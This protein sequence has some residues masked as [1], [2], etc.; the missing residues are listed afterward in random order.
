[1]AL[2]S[3]TKIRNIIYENLSVATS[4]GSLAANARFKTEH[5]DDAIKAADIKVVFALKRNKKDSL[6]ATKNANLASGAAIPS[7]SLAVVSVIASDGQRLTEISPT[8]LKM[9]QV[10]ST[11]FTSSTSK[12]FAIQGNILYHT[13]PSSVTVYYIGAPAYHTASTLSDSNIVSPQGFE[14]IVASFATAQLLMKRMD[15]PEE[16][17][18]YERL[19]YSGLE[20]YGILESPRTET[21]DTL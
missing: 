10:Y 2:A 15:R 4:Y 19:G 20:E 9:L 21:V 13:A 12:Y 6:L 16:A 18:F 1:M 11:A 17:Q 14:N 5:V 7:D 8:K 3:L